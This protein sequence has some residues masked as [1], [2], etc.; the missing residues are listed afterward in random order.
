MMTLQDI[1]KEFEATSIPTALSSPKTGIVL[2]VPKGQFD[3]TGAHHI[4]NVFNKV[5]EAGYINAIL[6]MS[7]VSYA[8]SMGIGAVVTFTTSLKKKKG[9]LVM[10]NIH[11]KVLDVFSLLGFTQFLTI[12]NSLDQAIKEF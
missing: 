10:M 9:K 12:A 5:L 8:A 2:I 1:E 7:S 11:P 4:Q 3:M 6:D